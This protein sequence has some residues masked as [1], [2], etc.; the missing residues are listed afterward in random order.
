MFSFRF[1]HHNVWLKVTMTRFVSEL[2]FSTAWRDCYLKCCLKQTMCFS[3]RA[4]CKSGFCYWL[5]SRNHRQTMKSAYWSVS[6]IP[7]QSLQ[8]RPLC[9][10]WRPFCNCRWRWCRGKGLWR[11]KCQSCTCQ[12]GLP[13]CPQQN[14]GRMNSGMTDNN[15]YQPNVVNSEHYTV[16]CRVLPHPLNRINF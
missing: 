5:V 2:A 13:P 16:F 1:R 14:Q 11:H 4:F 8:E 12:C 15:Q 3:T 7:F 10:G 9:L 6:W